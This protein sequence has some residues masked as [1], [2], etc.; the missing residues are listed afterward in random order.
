MYGKKVKLSHYRPGKPIRAPGGSDFQNF[1]TI[2]TRIWY[3]CRPYGTAAF[4]SQEIVLVPISV[5]GRVDCSIIMQPEGLNQRKVPMTPSGIEPA[6]LRLVA[7]CLN[8]QRHHVP[9]KQM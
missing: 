1:E 9:Q 4:T 5:R 7:L 8:R 3:D 2:G 6:A